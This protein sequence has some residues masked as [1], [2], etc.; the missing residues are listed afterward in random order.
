MDVRAALLEDER[1]R[2]P[3]DSFI[4]AEAQRD[5]SGVKAFRHDSNRL[6]A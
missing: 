3:R 1:H 4:K 5:I 2:R 6:R